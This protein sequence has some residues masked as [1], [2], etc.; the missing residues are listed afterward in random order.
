MCHIWY[1]RS[2]KEINV[3]QTF[4]ELPIHFKYVKMRDRKYIDFILKW[5]HKGFIKQLIY[6]ITSIFLMKKIYKTFYLWDNFSISIY[7]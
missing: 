4:D 1:L 2:F 5:V 7:T 3:S 6:G